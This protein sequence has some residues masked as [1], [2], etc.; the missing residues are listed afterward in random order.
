VDLHTFG[1]AGKECTNTILFGQG[2]IVR[3]RVFADEGFLSG[4]SGRVGGVL[5][6]MRRMRAECAYFAIRRRFGAGGYLGTYVGI[7]VKIWA[8]GHIWALLQRPKAPSLP[9]MVSLSY[10]AQ[11]AI[12][13]LFANSGC[14]GHL[15]SVY[16]PSL[17][18]LL[19][20]FPS[21][22]FS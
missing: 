8:S 4:T 15:F 7:W 11:K 10:K 21:F 18:Y 20:L 17:P 22:L 13:I 3:E 1:Q 6:R 14:S 9:L 19:F 12:Y 2:A 5:R 16:A